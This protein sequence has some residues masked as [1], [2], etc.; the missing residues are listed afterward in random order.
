ML[1]ILT[2]ARKRGFEF[3]DLPDVS[4]EIVT[5]SLAD[6][7]RANALFG[8]ISSALDEVKVALKE[9]P[10]EATLLDVG[11]GLGDIPCRARK[12]ARRAGIELT[13][14]GLDSAAELASASRSSVDFAV[15][16]DALRLPFADKSVD[17]VMCS[18]VL[19]HFAGVEAAQLLREMDRVARVRVIVSDIRRSWIA[20][21][22]LWLASFPLRFHAVSRHDGVV[23]VMRGF[24]P[25]ELEDTVHE[26][27]LWRPVAHRRRAFRVTTS[28][29][30]VHR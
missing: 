30:P 15:C 24:T 9:V 22:G 14:V 4:P 1:D 13:T 6:V 7:A 2:P 10:R 20:A 27:I 25:H 28:W 17:I 18:Q 16:A 3:L 12:E 11:T 23:S 5:R 26:A 8:G 29:A 19:H 21:I